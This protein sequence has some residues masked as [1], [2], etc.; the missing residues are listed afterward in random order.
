VDENPELVPF[1][2]EIVWEQQNPVIRRVQEKKEAEEYRCQ[3]QSAFQGI[4]LC[5]SV[6]STHCQ[7]L[8]G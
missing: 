2:S 8:L 3:N 1:A 5:S 6:I 7:A 4:H